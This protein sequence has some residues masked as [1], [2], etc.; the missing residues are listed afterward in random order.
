MPNFDAQAELAQ[1][2][3]CF[4]CGHKKHTLPF[5]NVR[6]SVHS[7]HGSTSVVIM[8][9]ICLDCWVHFQP[10]PMGPAASSAAA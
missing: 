8:Q 7:A 10:P 3:K 5:R 9:Y 6:R 2:R 4:L 1:V